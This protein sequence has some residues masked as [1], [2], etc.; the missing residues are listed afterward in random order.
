MGEESPIPPLFLQDG[1]AL[2][3]KPTEE[4]RKGLLGEILLP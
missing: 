2:R 3:A 1:F 4:K